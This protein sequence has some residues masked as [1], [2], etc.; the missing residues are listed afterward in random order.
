MRLDVAF[1]PKDLTE[2][3]TSVCIV[4]DALRASST[5]ATLFG[6]GVGTVAVAG[7]IEDA[8]RLHTDMPGSLLCGEAGGLPPPGFD[9]GNSPAE[10]ERAAIAG[11]AVVLAT[12]NGTR[13][14][15]AL[16]TAPA[17]FVGSLLN[18]TACARAAVAESRRVKTLAVVCS[19]TGLGTT[20]SYED[21]I[22]AG[23]YVDSIQRDALVG[24]GIELT[25]TALAALRLWRGYADNPRV[26]FE[27]SS[28]GRLLVEI[29][30]AEDL[31]ACA[32]VDR[33]AV[34]PR[35]R[36]TVDGRLLLVE[37]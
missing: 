5:V 15:A 19:G 24:D 23:A 11:R 1:L 29:G 7:T 17:V 35:L 28:H 2:P 16:D 22:V 4:I 30:L 26:A 31:D 33:Y 36:V 34:A 3:E 25:D 9:F 32:V 12:S 21:T 20:F 8:R 10:F 6:R 27:D 37:G 18:L 14:L 13:A